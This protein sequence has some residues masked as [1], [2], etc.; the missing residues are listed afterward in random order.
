MSWALACTTVEP[1][2]APV[3]RGTGAWNLPPAGPWF[4]FWKS[5]SVPTDSRCGRHDQDLSHFWEQRGVVGGPVTL[6]QQVTEGLEGNRVG[7][8][9]SKAWYMPSA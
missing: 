7:Q 1:T 4:Q 8:V 9:T 3:G 2:A 5:R 6:D